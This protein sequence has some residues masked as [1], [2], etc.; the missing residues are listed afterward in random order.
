MRV[1]VLEEARIFFKPHPPR[2]AEPVDEHD[3]Q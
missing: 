3:L 1:E 2:V